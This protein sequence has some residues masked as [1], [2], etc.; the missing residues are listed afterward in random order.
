MTTFVDGILHSSAY[1]LAMT[2][3]VLYPC[4]RR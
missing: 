3:L 2:F 4:C 1:V